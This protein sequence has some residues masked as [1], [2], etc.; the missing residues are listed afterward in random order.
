M[1]NHLRS[2]REY[3]DAL[4]SI[5]EV[6]PIEQAVDL[7]LELAAIIRNSYEQKA[8]APLFNVIKDIELGF[9]V[10][11]APAGVSR[12][13]GL[14][15]A[16]IA[17]SLGLNPRSTGQQIV[18]ALVAARDRPLIPPSIVQAA[19]CKENILLGD[20]V[21]LLRI[22]SPLLHQ[23][24]GGR[25]INTFGCI[26]VQTP[27]GEWTN[28]SIARIMVVD[29]NRMAGIVKVGQHIGDI[30]KL[31][32]DRGEPTPFA[33]ALGVEPAIPFVCGMPIP[34]WMNESDYLGA[35]FGEPINV[36]KC[37]TNNLYVPATAE[38]VIEGTISN[39][40]TAPEGPMG[41]YAG[42][43]WIGVSS[44]KPVYHVTAMTFRNAP[45]L[46]VVVAGEPVEEDHTAWGIP[47]AAEI[48]YTL[49]NAGLPVSMAWI[50]LE[51]ANHWAVVTVLRDW[52]QQSGLDTTHLCQRIGEC[53]FQDH[54]GSGMVKVLVMEDD[55]DP[56]NTYEVVWAYATRSHPGTSEH[57]F[58]KSP[59]GALSVYLDDEEKHTMTST[60]AVY[61]C[62]TRDEWTQ[63]NQPSRTCL[64]KGYPPHIVERVLNNWHSYGY[65]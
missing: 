31:W 49:R 10:L 2:L 52:R 58:A 6:Q 4:Q 42:Y 5:G 30:H 14:Y 1:L 39:T 46:P 23:G 34:S 51:S 60:K 16:R 54:V 3:I 21:D 7:D 47:N 28:W 29:R 15:L 62:L 35:Y 45:I 41:E 17:I 25:Y 63:G 24:D 18:E 64:R 44:N 59:T 11:G 65:R 57:V 12:Q 50:P 27:D 8:P 53:L 55:I 48:L 38:I 43:N 26:V 32:Q 37:E 19:P 36:A 33:L 61:N 13:P 22:P 40:D 56:T 9:R 20:E